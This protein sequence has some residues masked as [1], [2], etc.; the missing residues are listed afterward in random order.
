MKD[1]K[2]KERKRV[3][4][5]FRKKHKAMYANMDCFIMRIITKEIEALEESAELYKALVMAMVK[6]KINYYRSDLCNLY[7]GKGICDLKEGEP[8]KYQEFLEW[9]KSLSLLDLAIAHMTSIRR[10][11]MYDYNLEYNRRSAEE[12]KAIFDFLAKFGFS[13]SEEEQQILDG[14]NELYKRE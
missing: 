1:K 3:R 4:T 10:R 9:E 5:E 2:E 8:A 12:V 13:V 14:T 6:G 11:E 7:S